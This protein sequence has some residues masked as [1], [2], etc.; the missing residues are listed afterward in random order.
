VAFPCISTGVFGYPKDK[1]AP[2]ALAAVRDFLASNEDAF[3][4]I[5]FVCY[6]KA[7]RDYKIY[8]SLLKGLSKNP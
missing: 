1:A 3:D 2:V 8:E 5:I 6:G 7:L 4:E